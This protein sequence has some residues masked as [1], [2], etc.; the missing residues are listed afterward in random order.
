MTKLTKQDRREAETILAEIRRRP[1]YHLA[2]VWLERYALTHD[3]PMRMPEDRQRFTLATR[4]AA[5][6]E[7]A[8]RAV[9]LR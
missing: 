1:A 2:C 3:A 5:G 7:P 8:A 6:L 4:I 9:K